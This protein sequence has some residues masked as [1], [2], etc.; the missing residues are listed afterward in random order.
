[1]NLARAAA[2]AAASAGSFGFEA[3]SASATR[4]RVGVLNLETAAK[5]VIDVIHDRAF[6][7][8]EAE[9]IDPDL[10]AVVGEFLILGIPIVVQ[11]HAVLKAAATATSNPDSQGTI[12][13]VLTVLQVDQFGRGSIGDRDGGSDNRGIQSYAHGYGFIL[14]QILGI[15]VGHLEIMATAELP[16]EFDPVRL[17]SLHTFSINSSVP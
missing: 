4:S 12:R 9:R 2:T 6:H 13:T 8:T 1:M 5:N 11:G 15:R 7:V 10:N 3:G 16:G 14:R 17:S